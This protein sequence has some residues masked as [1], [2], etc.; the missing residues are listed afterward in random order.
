MR[1]KKITRKRGGLKSQS[2]TQIVPPQA[3]VGRALILVVAI[4]SFLACLTV[5]FVSLVRDAANDWN[6]DLVREI[7]VQ[8]R[9]TDGVN[10][11]QE[12][13]RTIALVQEF[14]GVGQARAYSD[15]ETQQLLQPWLGTGLALEELPVPRLILVEIADPSSLN[16]ID[17]KKTVE[18]DIRGA[19]LDDHRTW[20]R[21]L[22]AMANTVVFGGF[23]ILILVL[24]SMILSVIFA[25]RAAMAGNRDVVEVLHFVGAENSF[26]AGQFQK[27]FLFLG[28]KGGGA[29]G[30]I[31]IL[32]FLLLHLLSSGTVASQ[33]TS[34]MQALVGSISIGSMGYMGI[35][36]VVLL[37][38]FLTALTSR[39]AVHSHLANME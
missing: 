23:A 11:L 39:L 33:A 29:G 10:M 4:M 5:G 26:I 31:A 6:N 27:H 34:Q 14:P 9:P 19:S 7:T 15:K 36:F 32:C 22:S 12:I 17:M 16:I 30:A 20:T 8:I 13:D 18:R 35:I 1:S 2:S 38:A 28:L 37:V 25:T 21:Q 24:S 3:V